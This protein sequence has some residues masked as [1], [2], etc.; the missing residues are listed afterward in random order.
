[1]RRCR[2]IKH[3]RDGQKLP[4]GLV[5]FNSFSHRAKRNVAKGVVEKMADE[6]G[7]QNK[8]ASQ[9]DLPDADAADESRQLLRKAGHAIQSNSPLQ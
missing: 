4:E 7:K 2:A 5:I 1:M 8:P 6:I 3:D 9:T